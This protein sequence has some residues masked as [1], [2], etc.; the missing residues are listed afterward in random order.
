M[1][2]REA[3]KATMV[4]LERWR[5][6]SSRKTEPRFV[7]IKSRERRAGDP[8]VKFIFKE[9]GHARRYAEAQINPDLYQVITLGGP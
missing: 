7:V 9:F 1:N 5:F 4:I 2:L 8:E 3:K 6:L